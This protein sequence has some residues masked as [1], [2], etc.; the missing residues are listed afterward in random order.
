MPIRKV[1]VCMC[2]CV[3]LPHADRLLRFSIKNASKLLDY[4]TVVYRG[5]IVA[6]CGCCHPTGRWLF[7]RDNTRKHHS[8]GL[9]TSH[10]LAKLTLARSLSLA[11]AIATQSLVVGNAH[12]HN[13]A[14]HCER[15]H[16]RTRS[17]GSTQRVRARSA[18]CGCTHYVRNFFERV[19]RLRCLTS[20]YSR[21]M[22]RT[23][24][25]QVERLA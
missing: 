7:I 15:V 6:R 13:R 18:F 1:N 2:V 17:L 4:P 21:V 5:A 16:V 11:C 23:I 14:M 24:L 12:S 10:P 20:G 25:S 8:F 22:R 19:Q 9:R 3:Q